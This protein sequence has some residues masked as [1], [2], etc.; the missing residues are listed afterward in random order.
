MSARITDI[1]YYPVK[2]C[3]GVTVTEAEVLPTGLRDDRAYAIV[4]EKGDTRWQGGDPTLALIAPEPVDG[5]LLLRAPGMETL[6]VPPDG[7]GTADA[8][9]TEFLGSPSRLVR[10]PDGNGARLHVVSRATLDLLNAKLVERGEQPLPMDRFRPN[11]VI[12]GWPDPHT[13]DTAGRLALGGT[14][15][16]FTE[17]TIRCAV[18]MVDQST[19]TRSGPEPLRTL[20]DYRREPEGVALGAYY[21]VVRAGRVAVGDPASLTGSPDAPRRE[22]APGA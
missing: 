9:L 12:G 7:G 18:T 3:A 2:G 11:V 6:R 22:G 8:W 16:T 14:E 20:A 5:G 1:T 4:D 13:E 15:L 17:R 10:P 21:T 19:G